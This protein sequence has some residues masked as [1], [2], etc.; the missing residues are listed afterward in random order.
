MC[1]NDMKESV[2]MTVTGQ[3]EKEKKF[4]IDIQEKNLN[5]QR[6]PR[7]IFVNDKHMNF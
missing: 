4:L 2:N 1:S 6:L 3:S 7:G 5:R